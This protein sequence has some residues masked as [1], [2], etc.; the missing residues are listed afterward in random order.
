MMADDSNHLLLKKGLKSV[1]YQ[2]T[3]DGYGQLS[4]GTVFRM[5]L[6]KAGGLGETGVAGPAEATT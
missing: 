4:G 6:A 1:T 3:A 2:M 5:A